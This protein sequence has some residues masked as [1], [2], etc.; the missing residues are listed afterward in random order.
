[1]NLPS[2]RAFRPDASYYRTTRRQGLSRL[3]GGGGRRANPVAIVA[4]LLA[5]VCG[6]A[7]A[8]GIHARLV[9]HTGWLTALVGYG[10]AGLCVLLLA[11]V[12]LVRM[13]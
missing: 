3:R 10:S 6:L 1:M 2:R 7:A 5:I 13:R 9:G 11:F 12:G 8:W 4:L